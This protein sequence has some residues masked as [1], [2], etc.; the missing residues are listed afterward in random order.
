MEKGQLDD[1]ENKLIGDGF[2][3]R[4]VLHGECIVESMAEPM[5]EKINRYFNGLK[6]NENLPPENE[7]Q[8]RL[9]VYNKIK[10][11]TVLFEDWNG[12]PI[13]SGILGDYIVHE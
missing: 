10:A 3:E 6:E 11:H 7:R 12:E 13:S 1:E 4:P 8:F 9:T 2:E 5:I